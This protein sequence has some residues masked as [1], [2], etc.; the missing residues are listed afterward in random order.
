MW[1][2][3]ENEYYWLDVM[4]EGKIQNVIN[5]MITLLKKEDVRKDLESDE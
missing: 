2:R 1:F 3:K 4:M 5:K